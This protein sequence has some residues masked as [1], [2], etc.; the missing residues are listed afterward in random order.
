MSLA[1]PTS[2]VATPR[3]ADTDT[4]GD[5]R[6]VAVANRLG[7]LVGPFNY[8]GLPALSLPV[9]LD[10]D[11][12]PIGLQLVARPFGGGA[13]AAGGRAFDRAVGALRATAAVSRSGPELAA[14]AAVGRLSPELRGILITLLAMLVFGLMDAASKYLSTLYPITQIIWLR[15][16]FTIPLALLVLGPRG[17]S[18]ALRSAVPGCRCCARSCWWSRSGSWSGASAKCRWPTCMRCWRSP[19]WR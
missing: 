18:R 3:I 2:P 16:V 10:A 11:G 1:L 5:A 19:R 9:G 14:V 8:L 6:F 4:G 17:A 15:F 13:A 12:M 7:A